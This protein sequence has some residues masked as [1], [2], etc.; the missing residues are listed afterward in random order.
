[1]ARLVRRLDAVRGCWLDELSEDEVD[2]AV[3]FRFLNLSKRLAAI[4]PAF[5][6]NGV[7]LVSFLAGVD[8]GE[9][10]SLLLFSFFRRGFNFELAFI[11]VSY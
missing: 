5:E 1:M 10:I 8:V 9:D 6:P 2:E 3:L 4:S 7:G 11:L